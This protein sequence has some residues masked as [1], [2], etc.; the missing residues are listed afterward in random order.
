MSRD[1]GERGMTIGLATHEMGFARD[2][3]NRCTSSTM[4]VSWKLPRPVS[5]FPTL[6]MSGPQQFL[7]HMTAAGRL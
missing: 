6:V 3:A 7:Q 5:C 4:A 1:L 2:A